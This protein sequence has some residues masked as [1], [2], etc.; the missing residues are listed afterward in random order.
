MSLK[1]TPAGSRLRRMIRASTQL[2]PTDIAPGDIILITQVRRGHTKSRRVLWLSQCIARFSNMPVTHACMV[3]DAHRLVHCPLPE[4]GIEAAMAPTNITFARRVGVVLRCPPEQRAALLQAFN[5]IRSDVTLSTR[6]IILVGVLTLLARYSAGLPL[7]A[8]VAATGM[9]RVL[10]RDRT[11]M[12]CS[13]LIYAALQETMPSARLA[14]MDTNAFGATA[15]ERAAPYV[16]AFVTPSDFLF[17]SALAVAGHFKFPKTPLAREP[18]LA[19]VALPSAAP[20][21]E[22]IASAG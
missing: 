4:L 8:R 17:A 15:Q 19:T 16:A 12:T 10:L 11:R 9:R 7:L 20:A 14:R 5:R 2:E 21:A 18:A 1:I 13:Q 6:N 22:A 3:D